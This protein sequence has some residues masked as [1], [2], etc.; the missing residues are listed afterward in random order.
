[1]YTADP[2]VRSEAFHSM[3]PAMLLLI[4]VVNMVFR[5][6]VYVLVCHLFLFLGS[7]LLTVFVHVLVTRETVTV[8]FPYVSSSLRRALWGVQSTITVMLPSGRNLNDMISS[9][10]QFYVV[11]FLVEFRIYS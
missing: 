9:D 8:P 6:L 5:W 3:T 4:Y 10:G 11:P 7:F 1:M 2:V